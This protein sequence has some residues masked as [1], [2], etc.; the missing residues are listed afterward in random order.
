MCSVNFRQVCCDPCPPEE[1]NVCVPGPIQTY[2]AYVLQTMYPGAACTNRQSIPPS[3][4]AYDCLSVGSLRVPGYATFVPTNPSDAIVT[5]DTQVS[6]INSLLNSRLRWTYFS[7]VPNSSAYYTLTWDVLDG[8]A[9]AV[10]PTG[11]TFFMYSVTTAYSVADKRNVTV[12]DDPLVGCTETYIYPARGGILVAP[13]LLTLVSQVP[14]PRAA[15]VPPMVGADVPE[16]AIVMARRSEI[17]TTVGA[18][19][20]V[21]WFIT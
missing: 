20:V 19:R 14:V 12:I 5:Q 17:C 1:R 2:K 21:N 15:F 8:S 16:G 9:D 10:P 6:I 7:D 4:Q 3:Q 11:T 18:F 13:D